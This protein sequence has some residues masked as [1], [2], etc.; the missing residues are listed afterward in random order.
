[1]FDRF[2]ICQAHY[3][4][5]VDYNVG[6]WCRERPS[7]R[8]RKESTGVQLRRLGFRWPNP[9]Y[10]N[11]TENGREIYHELEKRYGY[12]CLAVDNR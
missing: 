7:N 1:M 4:I 8:R 2:D 11:L 9:G 5:E 10:E 12:S 3:L 6:G